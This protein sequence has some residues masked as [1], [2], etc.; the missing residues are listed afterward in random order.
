MQ[1]AISQARGIHIVQRQLATGE[2]DMQSTTRVRRRTPLGKIV[3]MLAA[4]AA[5]AVPVVAAWT[6]SADAGTLIWDASAANPAAPTD[7]SG[8]WNTTTDANWSSG[9]ADSFWVNDENAHFGM[10]GTAGTVTIDDAAGTASTPQIYF[11]PVSSG[12]YTIAAATGKSLTLTGF[13]N[14]SIASGVSP[15]ISAPIVGSAGLTVAG[16]GGTLNVAGANTFTGQVGIKSGSVVV[17]AGSNLGASTNDVIFGTPNIPPSSSDPVGSLTI[18]AGASVTVGSL[19][20][21]T[22]NA[23]AANTLAIGSGATLNVNSSLATPCRH[24]RCRRRRQPQCIHHRAHR[25]QSHD[26]RRGH[27]ECLRRR[28]QL[29]LHRRTRQQPLQHRNPH[30][31][32]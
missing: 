10:G 25:D 20:A 2:C 12:N 29:Q 9:A 32:A 22:N 14:I 15:T 28:G 19:S 4:A 8:N 26:Q 17:N 16:P 18:G 30:A 23:S 13:G 31:H 24:Q 5:G 6:Q 3:T 27:I 11:D 1:S 7:G 21:S